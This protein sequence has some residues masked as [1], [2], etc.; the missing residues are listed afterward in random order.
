MLNRKEICLALSHLVQF[1]VVNVH[2]IHYLFLCQ[3][4]V[5]LVLQAKSS[6]GVGRSVTSCATMCTRL[7][8]SSIHNDLESEED[9][10]IR[11]FQY[12]FLFTFKWIEINIVS[13]Q[14]TFH[15]EHHM[16]RLNLHFS[17]LQSVSCYRRQSS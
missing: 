6:G 11:I 10:K 16:V 2:S 12:S 4:A 7:W 1:I 5:F 17:A 8:Q 9:S 13:F 3:K 14:F 15:T